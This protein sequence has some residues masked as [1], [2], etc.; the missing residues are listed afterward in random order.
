MRASEAVVA[1]L[2]IAIAG[3]VCGGG[4]PA[5]DSG[6]DSGDDTGTDGGRDAGRDSGRDVGSDARVPDGGWS[7]LPDV[8]TG[9]ELLAA[10]PDLIAATTWP[11]EMC[12]DRPGCRRIAPIGDAP[13]GAVSFR[14]ERGHGI[15][16]GSRGVVAI[17]GDTR[18]TWRDEWIVDDRGRTL[19]GFRTRM[20]VTTGD[21]C[22]QTKYDVS[23]AEFAF[24]LTQGVA[25][26]VRDMLWRGALGAW[27]THVADLVEPFVDTGW[28]QEIRL[29]GLR[30]ASWLSTQRVQAVEE[31][32][33]VSVIA[34]TAPGC[35]AA[36]AD[37]VD[38]TIFVECFGTSVSSIYTQQ[39]GGALE[40]LFADTSVLASGLDSDGTDMVWFVY[41]RVGSEY[42]TELWTSPHAVHSAD[43]RAR[44]VANVPPIPMSYPLDLRVGFGHAASLEAEDV[45]AV[46]RL[47][48]GARAEIHAP[49]GELWNGFVQY[50][51][52]EEIAVTS[53]V[54]TAPAS[55]RALMFIRLDSLAFVP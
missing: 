5:P 51:G 50:I 8:P 30:T 55:D 11:V 20:P 3:C 31:D 47:S 41:S 17:L 27:P 13:P 16:D 15:H 38:D 32:G 26:E 52:P 34:G 42:M 7:P 40:A 25:G 24:V 48:D 12:P 53:G 46:Y 33:T 14:V 37:V 21:Q 54:S 43:V 49:D 29:D 36:I 4:G 35:S 6:R 1:A 9:C 22:F 44:R 2:M 18:P 23:S 10:S 39:P 19:A 45:V 28:S